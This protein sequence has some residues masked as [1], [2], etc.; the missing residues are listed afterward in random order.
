MLSN[1]GLNWLVSLNS[2]V[3]DASVVKGLQSSDATS[4]VE[5]G[6]VGNGI[7]SLQGV[8]SG[9]AGYTALISGELLSW[10]WTDALLRLIAHNPVPTDYPVVVRLIDKT[11]I[12][13]LD[14]SPKGELNF[15]WFGGTDTFTGAYTKLWGAA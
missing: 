10:N 5:Q 3:S 7:A 2:D 12:G 8:K 15:G 11:N 9:Q 1:P 13:S 14:I 6:G 4:K